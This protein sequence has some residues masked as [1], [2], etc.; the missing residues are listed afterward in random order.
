MPGT[1]SAGDP[2]QDELTDGTR[3]STGDVQHRTIDRLERPPLTAL[4]GPPVDRL[5]ADGSGQAAWPTSSAL[6]L[7]PTRMHF[8]YRDR[9]R[10]NPSITEIAHEFFRRLAGTT[11]TA[12]QR[13]SPRTP[14]GRDCAIA[15]KLHGRVGH[16]LRNSFP[17]DAGTDAC[18]VMREPHNVVHEPRPR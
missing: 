1:R 8:Y 7:R 10:P 18:A 15:R 12:D 2:H 5:A 11:Q 16:E 13:C 9:L 14:S 6:A 4:G 17:Q 3:V